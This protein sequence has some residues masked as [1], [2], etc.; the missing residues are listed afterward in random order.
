M[1]KWI[2]DHFVTLMAI[3]ATAITNFTI[4]LVKQKNTDKDV[5]KLTTIVENLEIALDNHKESSQPHKHCPVHSTE[6]ATVKEGLKQKMDREPCIKIHE[7]I[8]RRLNEM[9][10]SLKGLTDT[11][12]PL[13]AIQ[14]TLSRIE[15]IV[16]RNKELMEDVVDRA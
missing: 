1:E 11:L 14:E 16:D 5:T 6:L 2:A 15:K 12:A 9:G 3:L 7:S 8:D 4:V 10:T 13:G